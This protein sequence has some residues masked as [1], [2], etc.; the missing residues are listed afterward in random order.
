MR[1]KDADLREELR[2][3]LDMATADRV[4]R[5]Q[6]PGDAAAA[7]K[8]ELGN[9][10]QIHEATLDVWGTRWIRQVIQDVR[11]ALRIF[12][13]NAGFA[14]VAVL[15]LTLG[16]GANTA[17]FEVVNAVRL[18]P[19]PI[20]D[21]SSLF[22]IRIVDMDA[23]RGHVQTWH[24][25]VTDPVWKEIQAR[26][27]AFAG[28]FAWNRTPFNL[29]DRGEARFAE[30]LLVSGD[31]FTTLGISPALGRLLAPD[32]DRAGCVPRV[33]LSDGFWRSNYGADPSVVGRT[34]SLDSR[35]AEII[36]VAPR[37]FFGLEVGRAF[38]L[39]MPLCVE[40]IFSND[41]TGRLEAGTTWWLSVFGRL[42]PGWTIDR[43]VAHL[44]AISPDVFRSS[45]PAEYPPVSVQQYLDF[46]LSAYAGGSGLS[47]LRD[48]YA[49][50]LWL[51]L[52]IAGVVLVIACANLANLLFARAS[53]REREIAV[54]LGLGASRA[55]V[56]RQL[57]TE[58]LVLVAVGAVGALWLAGTLGEW[59]VAALGTAD[60]P[61]TL[62]LGVDWSVLGFAL[63][64]AVMTCLL[65]G[66]APAIRATRMATG[67]VMRSGGR[68]TASR[69]SLAIRRGL[70]VLQVALS[71]ALLFGSLLFART[72]GNVLSVDPGFRPDGLFVARLDL[73]GLDASVDR[74]AGVH[75]NVL[76]RIR[77]VP[78]VQAAARVAV[79][80]FGD[81]SGANTVWPEH[82][83]NQ[84]F[85]SS[86]NIVGS[87]FFETLG[88]PMLAGR[89]FDERDTPES[90]G[91]AIVNEMFASKF[92]G[93]VAAVGRR[94]T[95]ER[96]ARD[97]ETTFE[98]VG[99]VRESTYQAL[100]E[101]RGP[102]VYYATTQDKP[103]RSAQLIVRSPL[104]PSAATSAVTAALANTE[105]RIKVRYL[106]LPRMMSDSLV[107]DRLLASLSAGFGGLAAL[108]TLVGL[109][110][111]VSYTV[112]RR[113]GEIGIRMALGARGRDIGL[114]LLG[115]TGVLLGVGIV[116]GIGLALAGGYA[117]GAL[118][119]GVEPYDPL[120][121]AMAVVFL[122]LISAA[123]TFAPARRATHI[124]PVVALRLE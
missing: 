100:K 43:A 3:H 94:F 61:I 7:A 101:E 108:L 119:F 68:G 121:L 37:G 84:Q 93:S 62:S 113:T 52:S 83:P 115:E 71:V 54:R 111:L 70:V 89:D 124:E 23:A 65:F 13:R 107:Q 106:L 91:V 16:I 28:L 112:L 25:S 78:G 123:A 47:R 24:S 44:A 77:A 29:A 76:D 5:G 10:S 27:Q 87:R 41:G 33:V 92:G 72:L 6:M 59:L 63:T 17:L 60:D 4:A 30:G 35:S 12:R 2:T 21:P 110:G 114:L 45:L 69:E 73:S 120:T 64:L 85:N 22:E 19:V 57:L 102:V 38:D 90:T 118:L 79:V 55:R 11:Y 50:P 8:R 97:P 98:I 95:H 40:P 104:P 42:K 96:T 14:V 88:I 36:G 75:R 18:R 1:D 15:S 66:L 82:E 20:A 26:Q 122:L 99:V 117:A 81:F 46:K 116:C 105:P 31:F 103:G 49:D 74:L 109:Y 56:I 9:L 39:A 53:A 32:D 80:P 86:I 58:S 34:I 48:S 51:L 67:T